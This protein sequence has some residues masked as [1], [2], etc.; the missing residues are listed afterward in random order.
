MRFATREFRCFVLR[1]WMALAFWGLVMTGC[2]SSPEGRDAQVSSEQ[3]LQR[4][5]AA[6]DRI[7][8]I[9][10][11]RDAAGVPMLGKGLQNN[12][13]TRQ[14]SD[15]EMIQFLKEGRPATDP[16][17]TTGIDMPPRGGDSTLSDED[18]ALIVAYLRTL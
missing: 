1:P 17:N 8:A 4:G 7:C 13:F 9:C 3:A 6:Y 16:L 2:G 12:E 5:R 10:H 11:G 15:G 14:R 18:L